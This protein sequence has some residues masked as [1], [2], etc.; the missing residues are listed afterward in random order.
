M[1]NVFKGKPEKLNYVDL[2]PLIES[3]RRC[4]ELL[5]SQ[6]QRNI[7]A[8]SGSNDSIVAAHIAS[9]YGITEAV[10]E[11]S[12]CFPRDV[13]EYVKIGAQLGL[14]IEWAH[15][16]DM[17]WLKAHQ[18]MMFAEDQGAFYAH[19][20]QASVRETIKKRGLTGAIFGRHKQENTVPSAVYRNKNCIWSCHPLIDWKTEHVWQYIEQNG[21]PYPSIYNHLIGKLEGT[22][23]FVGISAKK[24]QE[25]GHNH[26][27]LI[28]D[29][30]PS[31]LHAI[32]DWHIPTCQYLARR[33]S[34]GSDC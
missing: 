11:V 14:N 2:T 21:L 30:D 9:E 32:K 15:R 19:R 7:I 18:E 31:V 26:F 24:A 28:Y 3:A 1:A 27:D 5:L 13:T 34:N 4:I 20:Q 33:F 8:F 22:D 23:P 29:Y 25:Y 6:S 10:C 12:F 16:L 17:A